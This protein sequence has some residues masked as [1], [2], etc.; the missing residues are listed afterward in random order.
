MQGEK[1]DHDRTIN[2]GSYTNLRK[3]LIIGGI[4]IN[5]FLFG[6][7]YLTLFGKK[8]NLVHLCLVNKRLL[9]KIDCDN[10]LLYFYQSDCLK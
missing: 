10:Y 4:I 6:Y 7:I 5:Y 8:R 9:S 2:L 1:I 3:K